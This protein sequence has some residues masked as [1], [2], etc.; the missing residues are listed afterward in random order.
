MSSR[1]L[2]VR[3]LEKLLIIRKKVNERYSL[4]AL[5]RDL[6]VSQAQLSKILNGQKKISVQISYKVGLALQLGDEEL[7]ILL[8]TTLEEWS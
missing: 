6:G 8:R 3:Y 5:S 1:Q 4:H 2:G 7:L